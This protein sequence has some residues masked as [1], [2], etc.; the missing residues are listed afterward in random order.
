MKTSVRPKS[1][2]PNAPTRRVRSHHLLLAAIAMALAC[3]GE[4]TLAPTPVGAINLTPSI[5]TLTSKGQTAQLTAFVVDAS[6]T[7]I[8]G[9]NVV[10]STTDVGLASVGA[11]GIVTAEGPNGTV[12]IRAV[13]DG[14]SGSA[15]IVIATTSSGGT[16]V[17]ESG[18]VTLIVPQGAVTTPFQTTIQ[19][20]APGSSPDL[21]SGTAFEFGP[22][23]TRFAVPV[24]L[25]I[26]Y[27][28]TGLPPGVTEE[29]LTLSRLN[30]G[31]WE[32]LTDSHVDT[33]ANTVSASIVSFSTYGILGSMASTVDIQPQGATVA[34]SQTVQ[35]QAVPR[36]ADGQPL[37]GQSI[38]WSSDDPAVAMVDQDGL[39]TGVALGAV[40]IFARAGTAT[41]TSTVSV[42]PTVASVDISP[43]VPTLRPG[44]V[45]QLTATARDAAGASIPGLSTTWA[46]NNDQAA[47]V[48]QS[49]QLTAVGPGSATVT[50]TIQGVTG[51]TVVTVRLE[52]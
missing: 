45:M 46:S 17:S 10:W 29:G 51:A 23:N 11:S 38:I 47:T 12:T 34:V 9:K 40:T 4:E 48:D 7:V 5:D 44:A 43:D 32:G 1:H 35:L 21:V 25:T 18:T 50:A 14:V 2:H 3:S 27:D 30:G 41:G 49:G 22:D 52:G 24:R 6:G 37:T 16:V 8:P 36:D 20:I 13:A 42:G 31:V 28:P 19:P 33:T 15:V 39:V 26:E